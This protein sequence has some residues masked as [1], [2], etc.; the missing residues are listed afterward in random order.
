MTLASVL[1]EKME[2]FQ[3]TAK[4]NNSLK[5]NGSKF[6]SAKVPIVVET[7]FGDLSSFYLILQ[8]N[9]MHYWKLLITF[10]TVGDAVVWYHRTEIK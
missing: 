6:S 4:F 2:S 8:H 7:V 9:S 5:M 3:P 10:L 1:K